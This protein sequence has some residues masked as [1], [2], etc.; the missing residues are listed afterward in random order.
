MLRDDFCFNVE[1][2]AWILRRGLDEARG[3][4]WEGVGYYHSHDPGH[5]ADYLRKVLIQALRLQA[6]ERG[7]AAAPAPRQTPA[8]TSLPPVI[9]VGAAAPVAPGS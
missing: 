9:W 1:G 3:D 5:K 7:R 6:A 4:L 8:P 2:G